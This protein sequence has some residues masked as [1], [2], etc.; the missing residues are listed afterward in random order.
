M[1]LTS[2]ANPQLLLH[3]LN[4]IRLTTIQLRLRSLLCQVIPIFKSI[5][6]VLHIFL[7][8]KQS[9]I[10]TELLQTLTVVLI[11]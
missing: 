7:K 6:R 1:I 10:K 9:W 5:L 3:S 11:L 8:E 2:K 4:Q